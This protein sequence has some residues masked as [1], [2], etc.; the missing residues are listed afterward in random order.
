MA[1][2]LTKIGA[3]LKAIRAELQ[4]DVRRLSSVPS[5]VAWIWRWIRHVL[6]G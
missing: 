5:L 1:D 3:A 4:P 6:Y 2:K